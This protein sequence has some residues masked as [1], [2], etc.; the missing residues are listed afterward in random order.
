MENILKQNYFAFQNNIYQ[1]EKGDSMGSP[2][3]GKIHILIYG[4]KYT[5]I[6]K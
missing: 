3:S 2:I 5:Q 1:P 4:T 6:Y